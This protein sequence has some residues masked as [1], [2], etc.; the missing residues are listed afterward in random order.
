M[1]K[2]VKYERSKTLFISKS[3]N[4]DI[5]L[6]N[7]NKYN[8]KHISKN[9]MKKNKI[10]VIYLNLIISFLCISL[11]KESF[12][13]KKLSENQEIIITINGSGNKKILGDRYQGYPD[14]LFIDGEEYNG[15]NTRELNLVNGRTTIKLSYYNKPTNLAYIFEGLEDLIKVDFSNCDTSDVNDMKFMF[16][17]CI[18]LEEINFGNFKTSSV[19]D[20]EGMFMDCQRI[21]SLDL[22][23][24]NTRSAK[25]MK[26]MFSKCLILDKIDVSSFDTSSVTDM[27]EMFW[28]CQKLVSIDL[29]SFTTNN[30]NMGGMLKE[31]IEL[32]SISFSNTN[33]LGV[34]SLAGMFQ[35]CKK[36]TSV[37]F[38]NFDTS[39]CNDFQYLFDN[40][41]ELKNVNF[42]SID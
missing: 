3:I 36:L 14:Q 11:S 13:L 19:L 23:N 20:M 25:N 2:N 4:D 1:K 37:D 35:G 38:S 40:C 22:S 32:Q 15:G 42:G 6:K 16:N 34:S 9:K 12:H 30:V 41:E 26:Q 31:C 24:F 39:D 10:I 18:N 8:N 27:V 5:L 28:N 7:I 21:T 33:R 29:S 17:Y